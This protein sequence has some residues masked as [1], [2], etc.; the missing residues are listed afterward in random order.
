M[1]PKRQKN[2]KWV[3]TDARK[4][5]TM[6]INYAKKTIELTKSEMKAAEIYGSEMYTALLDAQKS[7]P[8]FIVKVKSPSVKRDNYK[9]LTREFMKNYIDTHDD[10]EHSAMQ[11]FNTLCGLTADGEKKAFAAVAS[12]GELRMW[13]LTKFPEL[14]DMQSTINSIME[15]VRQ[16][17][18]ENKAA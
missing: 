13:F 7:F 14:S 10:D 12:Y 15:R 11:E 17:R 9:G 2:K 16:E 18:G 8:D 1:A 5:K 4:V 6:K 3:A